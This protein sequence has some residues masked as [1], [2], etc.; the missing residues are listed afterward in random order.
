MRDFIFLIAKIKGPWNQQK[1]LP[2]ARYI[3]SMTISTIH[4]CW[5]VSCSAGVTCNQNTMLKHRLSDRLHFFYFWVF[6][7]SPQLKIPFEMW[8][9]NLIIVH[10]WKNKIKIKITLYTQ[11]SISSSC[12]LIP[13]DAGRATHKLLLV[14]YWVNLC[15]GTRFFLSLKF[16]KFFLLKTRFLVIF[17][18]HLGALRVVLRKNVR[19]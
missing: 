16:W 12:T 17:K 4:Y 2:W 10:S 19:K 18:C 9:L 11:F 7:H 15:T 6:D 5:L 1:T 13:S 14:N 8:I 3:C